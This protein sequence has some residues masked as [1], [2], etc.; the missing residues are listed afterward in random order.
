MKRS[1]GGEHNS[2]EAREGTKERERLSVS[3]KVG[4]SEKFRFTN[5]NLGDG[6]KETLQ[7]GRHVKPGQPY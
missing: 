6:A 3:S 4:G 2:R 1:E 7:N 5:S